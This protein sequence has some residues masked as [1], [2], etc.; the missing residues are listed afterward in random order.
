MLTVNIGKQPQMY[1]QQL[2]LMFNYFFV[3]M[4]IIH[5]LT[6]PFKFSVVTKNRTHS[7]KILHFHKIHISNLVEGIVGITPTCLWLPVRTIKE[8][9]IK[10]LS[11]D[12][13]KIG[14][15]R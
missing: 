6:I 1:E 9:D 8:R 4:L 15:S 14:C 12:Q 3:N 13:S 5:I 2:L 10:P 7:K 11:L